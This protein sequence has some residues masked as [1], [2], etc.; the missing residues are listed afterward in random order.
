MKFKNLNKIY[1]MK[2]HNTLSVSRIGGGKSSLLN[3]VNSFEKP[4]SIH[5]AAHTWRTC[6]F[7]CFA[8]LLFSAMCWSCSRDDEEVPTSLQGYNETPPEWNDDFE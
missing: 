2:I 7:L 1:T 6:V 4:H 3:S 5:R 8:V